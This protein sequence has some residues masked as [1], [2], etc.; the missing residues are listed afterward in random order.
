M[1]L[2]PTGVLG[3][4]LHEHEQKRANDLEQLGESFWRWKAQ[5]I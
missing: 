2:A 5:Q 1:E 3:R 4:V